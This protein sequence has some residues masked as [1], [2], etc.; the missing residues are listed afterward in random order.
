MLKDAVIREKPPFKKGGIAR[1]WL[2]RKAN[3]WM[4][5]EPS[6]AGVRIISGGECGR[7]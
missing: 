2:S 6:P 4:I 5:E 7:P 3:L 1:Y